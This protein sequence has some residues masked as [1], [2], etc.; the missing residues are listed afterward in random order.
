MDSKSTLNKYGVIGAGSFGIAIANLL[1]EN[2]EVLLY[3]RTEEQTKEINEKHRSKDY[4]LSER[5]RATNDFKQIAEECFLIFPIVPS[6]SF[7][8][9]LEEIAPYLKPSHIL[10]HGTKG[11]YTPKKIS[12][13]LE[14]K[15]SDVFTMS[16]LIKI[17]T[18]VVRIGCLAGPNLATELSEHQPAAT[19]IASEFNEVIDLGQKALRSSRFQ[20]YGS[21]ELLGVELAGVLK[22]YVAIASGM[23]TGLGYGENARALL[24]TRGM[25]ELIYVAKALG[26]SERAF[27]GLAGIGDLIATCNSPKSRN[28]SVGLQLAQGKKLDEIIASIGEV[29]EGVKTLQIVRALQKYGYKAPLAEILYKIIFEDL[30]IKKGI[31]FLMRF[32]IEK[33]ADYI[34]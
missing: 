26:A 12:K 10:I 3:T 2:G 29:A 21:N 8:E 23:L 14:L 5:I 28:Y 6:D 9:M 20:V 19:V 4:A 25:A 18:G 15:K 32:T 1:A 17:K 24:I 34:V 7:V 22:N 31:D 13:E 27:L 11:L 33:D 16:E 30:P